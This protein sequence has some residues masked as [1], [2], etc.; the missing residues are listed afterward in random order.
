MMKLRNMVFA[1]TTCLVVAFCGSTVLTYQHLESGPA[2]DGLCGTLGRYGC[3]GAQGNPGPDERYGTDD[4]VSCPEQCRRSVTEAPWMLDYASC[5]AA[6]ASCA[7]I[8]RCM[9]K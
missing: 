1:G 5:G 7:E 3:P 4:D 2:C 8:D 9:E 6:A